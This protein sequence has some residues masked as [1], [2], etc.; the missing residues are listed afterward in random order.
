MGTLSNL[1]FVLYLASGPLYRRFLRFSFVHSDTSSGLEFR[2]C[3]AHSDMIDIQEMDMGYWCAYNG[4]SSF[5]HWRGMASSNRTENPQNKWSL[6][7]G[8]YLLATDFDL[9]PSP[10]FP[11][12][13]LKAGLRSSDSVG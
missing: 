9:P 13:S 6:F 2:Q 3:F 7:A 8:F 1:R 12:W 11:T 10:S 4:I 5:C